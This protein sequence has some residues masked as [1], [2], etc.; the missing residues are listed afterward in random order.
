MLEKFL[1]RDVESNKS[2]NSHFISRSISL[3]A[4][5]CINAKNYSSFI[6]CFQKYPCSYVGSG[7]LL[8]LRHYFNVASCVSS[9]DRFYMNYELSVCSRMLWLN[10]V[11]WKFSK[12]HNLLFEVMKAWRFTFHVPVRIALSANHFLEEFLQ[13]NQK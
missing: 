5:G 13:L 8:R 12:N 3:D 11:T 6:H 7:S 9:S 1:C 2:L 4:Q 10:A